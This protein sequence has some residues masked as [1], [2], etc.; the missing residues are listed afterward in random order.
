MRSTGAP[1]PL[2]DALAAWHMAAAGG[3][4]AELSAAGAVRLGVALT[5][6]EREASLVRGGNGLVAEFAGGHLR[7]GAARC[8][9][10]AC[11]ATR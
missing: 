9:L 6:A 3:T 7:I 8:R 10:T 5:G 2:A 11:G 1:E 4:A